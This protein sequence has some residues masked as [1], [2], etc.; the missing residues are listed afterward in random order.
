MATQFTLGTKT[1]DNLD[2]MLRTSPLI[3]LPR[4]MD[5]GRRIPGKIGTVVGQSNFE[6]LEFILKCY[7]TGATDKSSLKTK[8]RTL[9][10]HLTDD[11]GRPRELALSFPEEPGKEYTVKYQ[12]DQLN[13]THIGLG[14]GIFELRLFAPDPRAK[15]PEESQ[16]ENITGSPE[17]FE[18]E[19]SGNVKTP[20][21]VKI[22]NNGASAISSFKLHKLE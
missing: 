17:S 19:N 5:R 22:T 10:D 2:L 1:N 20:V 11:S 7:I 9:N 14:D 3:M 15:G 6:G 21:V 13:A 18:I 4:S 16:T 8:I 12:G